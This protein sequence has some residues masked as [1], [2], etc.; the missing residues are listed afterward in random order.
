MAIQRFQVQNQIDHYPSV[1][2]FVGSYPTY[3]LSCEGRLVLKEGLGRTSKGRALFLWIDSMISIRSIIHQPEITPNLGGFPLTLK[4]ALL[5]RKT[6]IFILC[7]L[8]EGF[9]RA[10]TTVKNTRLSPVDLETIQNFRRVFFIHPN[11]EAFHTSSTVLNYPK[12]T[13][14]RRFFRLEFLNQLWQPRQL[15]LEFC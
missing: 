5:H 14:L 6:T 7:P 11:M 15:Q 8:H 13:Q 12:H 9:D 2:P 3:D 4:T 10:T 1:A